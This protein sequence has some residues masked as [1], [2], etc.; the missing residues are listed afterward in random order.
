MAQHDDVIEGIPDGL[1]RRPAGSSLLGTSAVLILALRGEAAQ[2][3]LECLQGND[4]SRNVSLKKQQKKTCESGRIFLLLP[5]TRQQTLQGRLLSSRA[6]RP[7]PCCDGTFELSRGERGRRTSLRRTCTAGGSDSSLH[8]QTCEE[9]LKKSY[10]DGLLQSVV[11]G[12]LKKAEELLWVKAAQQVQ[13]ELVEVRFQE[14]G[15]P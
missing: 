15:G 13:L 9:T 12:R 1:Q 2:L 7:W 5:P 11:L 10:L 8:Q 4:S 14:Q 3:L 6:G